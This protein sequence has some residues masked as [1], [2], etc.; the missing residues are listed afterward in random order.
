MTSHFLLTL[1]FFALHF[2]KKV[3]NKYIQKY[4]C[5]AHNKKML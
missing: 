2:L 4:F 3:Y 1:L 5:I